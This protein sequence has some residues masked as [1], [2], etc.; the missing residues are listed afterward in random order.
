MNDYPA[1]EDDPVTVSQYDDRVEEL[2]V[3]PSH[4]TSCYI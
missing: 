1:F 2:E 3:L 4:L